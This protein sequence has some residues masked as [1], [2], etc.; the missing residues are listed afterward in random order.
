VLSL[1]ILEKRLCVGSVTTLLLAETK[2][3]ERWIPHQNS[4]EHTK[5]LRERVGREMEKGKS[6]RLR[7]EKSELGK[8]ETGNWKVKSLKKGRRKRTTKKSKGGG[9]EKRQKWKS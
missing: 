3:S 9:K 8:S 6:W 5:R 7:L 4:K 1:G 2:E